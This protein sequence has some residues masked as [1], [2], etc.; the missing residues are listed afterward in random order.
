MYKFI[1]QANDVNRIL[2][3]YLIKV[4]PNVPLSRLQ[5]AFRNHDIKVNG[6]RKITKDYKLS[7]NDEIIVY[8][9]TNIGEQ[10]AIIKVPINFKVLFED[11]NIL[12]VSKQVNDEVHGPSN[13]LDNQV[14]SYLNFIPSG[15]F[16]PAHVGRIDKHASGI[17]LFG[18][19]YLALTQLKAKINHFVK[20]Y[21]FKS[22]LKKNVVAKLRLSHN[23]KLT[24]EVESSFGKEAITKFWIQGEHQYAQLITGRK[25][26]IRASLEILG[27]PIWGDRKYGG[28][29]AKRL[30]LHHTRLIFKDLTGDLTYLND[31]EIDD[32]PKW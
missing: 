10:S 11:D 24:K 20:I 4:L 16:T 5:R 28:K 25:H 26:Q 3:K 31:Q 27:T 1:A 22:D 18:K 15:S 8:G 2:Y 14:L 23:D 17:V 6:N 12:V 32:K 21:E 9:L 13:S 7:L 29:S 30:Y 19:T